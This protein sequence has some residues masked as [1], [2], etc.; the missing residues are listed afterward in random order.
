MA[1]PQ[2]TPADLHAI[3]A[4]FQHR[5]E[6]L[7]AIEPCLIDMP[8]RENPLGAR[9]RLSDDF[10]IGVIEPMIRLMRRDLRAAGAT[11]MTSARTFSNSIRAH[12]LRAGPRFIQT[13]MLSSANTQASR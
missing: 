11:F 9:M 10:D 13:P 7:R 12:V 5:I 4:A 3:L 8:M 2:T 6:R 1:H